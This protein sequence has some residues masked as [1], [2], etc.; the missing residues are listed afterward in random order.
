MPNNNKTVLSLDVGDVRIG[1]ALANTIAKM[2]SPLTTINNDQDVIKTVQ[3][4]INEHQASQ[5]VIGLPRGLDGQ[6]TA[7][8]G[9]ARAFKEA[10]SRQIQI[11]VYL[12]DEAATSLKAKAELNARGKN[13]QKGDVD[14]L[15]ATYILEDFL[16]Q[17]GDK[18]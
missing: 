12:M 1:V 7:Q 13:Y 16:N 6:E 11:P 9:K 2:A 17:E 15:A 8:T 14:A 18:L 3:G 10:L 5:L 4:L